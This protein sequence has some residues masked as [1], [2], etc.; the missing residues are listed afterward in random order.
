LQLHDVWL[1]VFAAGH[2]RGRMTD[3]GIDSGA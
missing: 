3:S 1:V 2:P